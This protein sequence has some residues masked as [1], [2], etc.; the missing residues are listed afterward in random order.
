MV[1]DAGTEGTVATVLLSP[2][3]ATFDMFEDYAAR[4]RAFVDA[5][6]RLAL[7]RGAG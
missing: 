2:A 1:D 6:G 3:A 5:A 4:R 7:S